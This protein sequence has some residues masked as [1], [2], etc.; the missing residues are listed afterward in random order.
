MSESE[1]TTKWNASRSPCT[2]GC[3]APA[4][5]TQQFETGLAVVGCYRIDV[6][7]NVYLIY[8]RGERHTGVCWRARIAAA[9]RCQNIKSGEIQSSNNK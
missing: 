5:W 7:V 1:R 4:R 6:H 3:A 8:V 9:D 2:I